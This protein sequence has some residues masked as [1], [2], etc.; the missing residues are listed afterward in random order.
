[1]EIKITRFEKIKEDGV[2]KNV[3]IGITAKEGAKSAYIDWTADVKDI[4]STKE[5]LLNYIKEYMNKIT[6]Q[7]EIDDAK[8]RQKDDP[9]VVIPEPQTIAKSLQARLNAPVV[10]READNSVVDEEVTL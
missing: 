4:G 9:S 1:M 6:N 7:A 8:E 3:V 5:D 2:L 10:T